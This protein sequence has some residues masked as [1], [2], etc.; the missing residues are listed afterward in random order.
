VTTLEIV[1]TVVA[2]VFTGIV[3]AVF[4]GGGGQ[5]SIPF[6]ILALGLSQHTAEGTSLMVIVPTAAIGALVHSRA[7]YVRWRPA[8]W[9]GAAGAMGA[10]VGALLA[11][12]TDELV[13]R[14][15]YAAFV[16]FVAFRFLR[17]RR[18]GPEDAS[19]GEATV[20]EADGS[21]A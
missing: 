5:V 9:L 19:S 6:M 14:R 4:G 8:L 20:E 1:L 12:R 13:L 2:G 15:I 11:V 10:A 16:L 21:A 7:G 18:R 17:P 3:S